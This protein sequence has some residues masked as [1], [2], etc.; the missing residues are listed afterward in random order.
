MRRSHVIMDPADNVATAIVELDKGQVV[1]T[2]AGGS[3]TLNKKIAMGHKFALDN[4]KKGENVIKYGEVIGTAKRDIAAGDWVHS[5]IRSP[6]AG[7]G[8]NAV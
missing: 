8:R 7:G 5:N 2:G 1:E 4:I 6:Y 3:I